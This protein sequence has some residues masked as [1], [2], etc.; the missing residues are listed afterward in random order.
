[1]GFGEYLGNASVHWQVVH[2]NGTKRPGSIK[3]RDP[4]AFEQIGV[5]AERGLVPG[6]FRVRLRFGSEGEALAALAAASV[7]ANGG[8]HFLHLDVPAVPRTEDKVEPAD[9]P[10]EVRVDW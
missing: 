6:R 2:H 1:M 5:D 4:I 9:P 7:T 8:S 3:G 10:A